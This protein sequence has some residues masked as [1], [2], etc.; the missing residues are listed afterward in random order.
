VMNFTEDSLG[1]AALGL[2]R[3]KAAYR[4]LT[5]TTDGEPA[6]SPELDARM[7]AALD[8]DV[9]TAAALAVLYDV[10]NRSTPNRE[11]LEYW[12]GVL[13]VAPNPS[14]LE[15]PSAQLAH[16]FIERLQQVLAEANIAT[17]WRSDGNA[18][19]E[20]AIEGVIGLRD[21]ARRN[22]DWAAS[23]RLRDVLQRCGVEVKDSKEGTTWSVAPT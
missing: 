10:V 21:E 22:K 15:E 19:P 20:E 16:D 8:D 2:A 12:L 17:A 13:G 4:K 6:E 14:W 23:D 7:E 3:I 11:R 9:N 18:T 5:P 1:A